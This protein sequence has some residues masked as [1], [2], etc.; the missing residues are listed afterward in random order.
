[1]AE[2]SSLSALSSPPTINDFAAQLSERRVR[3]VHE[4][5]EMDDRRPALDILELWHDGEVEP[6]LLEVAAGEVDRLERDEH[7]RR[8]GARDAQP[9]DGLV[10]A[11]A[12]RACHGAR[13]LGRLGGGGDLQLRRDRRQVRPLPLLREVQRDVRLERR[14]PSP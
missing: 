12:G 8:P 1:M 5:E 7:R 10:C 2:H 13:Y 14:R 6:V 11:L 4:R 3:L 9:L